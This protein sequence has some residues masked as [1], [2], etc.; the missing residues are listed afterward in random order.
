MIFRLGVESDT[1]KEVPLEEFGLKAAYRKS[2]L[3]DWLVLEL[4]TSLTWPKDREEQPRKPSWGFGLG[5]EMY[6]GNEEFS[7]RPV[8]F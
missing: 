1:A 8:T 2:V 5:C 6:F 7:S 3:R 4:R